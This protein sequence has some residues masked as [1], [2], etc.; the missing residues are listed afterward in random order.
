[1][2][3]TIYA[4]GELKKK[5]RV[6]KGSVTVLARSRG[7]LV[8]RRDEINALWMLPGGMP[9]KGESAEETVR[10]VLGEALGEAVFDV[11]PL[12]EYS[13]AGEDGKES[14]GVAYTADVREW[15]DERE[16]HAQAFSRLPL[17][18]QTAQAALVFALHRWAGDFFDERLELSRLGEPAPF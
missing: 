8:L 11:K 10:R 13:V 14:G 5:R 18:S 15:P 2:L 16:A 6:E 4:P 1:M 7:M 17:G 9:M 3:C 12:C